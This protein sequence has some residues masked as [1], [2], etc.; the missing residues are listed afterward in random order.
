MGFTDFLKH[1]TWV[2]PNKNTD[3][4]SCTL[5]GSPLM[6]RIYFPFKA[7]LGFRL[8]PVLSG[9]ASDSAGPEIG[10]LE[11]DGSGLPINT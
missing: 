9:L 3:Q 7:I 4:L 8:N 2:T 6:D 1:R 10:C 11:H 5:Y